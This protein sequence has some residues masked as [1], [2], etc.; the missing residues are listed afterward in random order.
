MEYQ[1]PACKMKKLLGNTSTNKAL[2]MLMRLHRWQLNLFRKLTNFAS[3]SSKNLS[4]IDLLINEN[5]NLGR[6]GPLA[7][8]KSA[9]GRQL[10]AQGVK[11]YCTFGVFLARL[12]AQWSPSAAHGWHKLGSKIALL[13]KACNF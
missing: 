8:P 3:K 2:G 13:S 12:A 5:I 11:K 4:R 7:A 9:S 1:E 10:S 6:F